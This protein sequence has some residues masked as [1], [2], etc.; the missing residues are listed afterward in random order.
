MSVTFDSFFFFCGVI[1]ND[2]PR[3]TTKQKIFRTVI[4]IYVC[5]VGYGTVYNAIY[6][7]K[8]SMTDE[9]NEISNFESIG[10]L[11]LFLWFWIM[12][13][14][15]HAGETVVTNSN[16]HLLTNA[17]ER[18]SMII[19]Y[20]VPNT[21]KI[22]KTNVDIFLRSY[23]FY[24][25]QQTKIAQNT[26]SNSS[27]D[28]NVAVLC[29]KCDYEFKL[30]WKCHFRYHEHCTISQG[31][32]NFV[33]KFLFKTIIF[34][35]F[36]KAF[37]NCY[38]RFVIC[39]LI[40]SFIPMVARHHQGGSWLGDG[41]HND[42][43]DTARN[44][45]IRAVL[46]NCNFMFWIQVL[47]ESLVQNAFKE[48]ST[49]IT[50]ITKLI[51]IPN[52]RGAKQKTLMQEPQMIKQN[53]GDDAIVA[54]TQLYDNNLNDSEESIFAQAGLQFL[55]LDNPENLISF[56]EIRD[57][58]YVFGRQIFGEIE[59]FMACL[60]IVIALQTLYVLC[61]LWLSDGVSG[62][63]VWCNY[64]IFCLVLIWSGRVMWL[65][66]KF[67]KLHQRQIKALVNQ[68]AVIRSEVMQSS[69]FTG[70]PKWQLLKVGTWKDLIQIMRGKHS[71]H[72]ND[73][74]DRNGDN[75][76]NNDDVKDNINDDRGD[77][78]DGNQD[79]AN[80]NRC[81]CAN[82]E[83]NFNKWK[84][85]RKLQ[86]SFDE[87]L[88]LLQVVIDHT[89][90][91]DIHPRICGVQLSGALARATVVSMIGFITGIIKMLFF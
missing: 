44:T 90:L 52:H 56:M 29:C 61:V 76:N 78:D 36:E 39:S 10:P 89:D 91:N 2:I 68:S 21:R 26:R 20:K 31:I 82:F 34:Q 81:N 63:T 23:Q 50:E 48:Y 88:Q 66:K 65:G 25:A 80:N 64:W 79:N 53:S 4:T 69:I 72:S 5:L 70:P 32:C 13:S 77:H 24:N 45:A 11:C 67:D 62:Q 38:F 41:A 22:Y 15:W 49:L 83:N 30:A 33:W 27:I 47:S 3:Q 73:N 16:L 7:A 87:Y 75:G 60:G 19:S 59:W 18:Q 71:K 58:A 84:K 55:C 85:L 35:F 40:L 8:Y 43:V 28:E 1:C 42:N 46:L 86:A 14:S 6:F 37:K 51:E 54:A 17:Q 12:V 9:Q 74:R 57:Y